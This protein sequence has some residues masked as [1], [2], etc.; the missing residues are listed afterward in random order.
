LLMN[1][2]QLDGVALVTVTAPGTDEG[3]AWDRSNCSHPAE[4]RCSGKLGCRVVREAADRW[5]RDCEARLSKLHRAAAQIARRQHGPGPIIGAKTWED[6]SRGVQHAHIVVPFSTPR[7][8]ARAKAYAAALKQLAPKHWFGFVDLR[9]RFDG[10]GGGIKAALYCA[11]YVSKSAGKET[12]VRRPV[13]IG[14]FLTMASGLTMRL[15][16]WRRYIWR[17]W[18]FRPGS[19]ELRPLVALLQAFPSLEYVGTTVQPNGP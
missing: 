19:D 16:R 11:K 15:L 7:E 9:K 12:A 14:R 18:G 1:L 10:E 8:K 5:N 3:L 2:V 13:F 4:E 17:R 6:Q